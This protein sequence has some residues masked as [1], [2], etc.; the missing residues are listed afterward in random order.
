[1]AM[2]RA[3]AMTWAELA[4]VALPAVYVPLPIGN[5]E[6]R[7]NAEP[8]VAAGGGMLVDNAELSPDWIAAHLLPVLAD[9]AR[10]AHMSEAAG[11]MGRRDADVALARMVYDV[12]RQAGAA[13]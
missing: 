11:R 4:A 8:I 3:G 13:R 9:P 1:M 10:V 12:V 5:G 7:L 2:C 6:Q